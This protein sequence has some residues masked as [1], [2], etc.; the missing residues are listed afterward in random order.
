MA[1]QLIL[2]TL[3]A[4]CIAFS[5]TA[6]APP[7]ATDVARYQLDNL[8]G[9]ITRSGVAIDAATSSDGHG[10]LKVTATGPTTVRLFETGDLDI[11]NARLTY[12]ARLR[13]QDLRGSAYL[14]MWCRFPGQG[15]FFSRGLDS[16]LSGTNDWTSQQTPFFLQPG[17]NPDLVKLNLV[18]NGTGT[19]WID[20]IRL[21]K[22][23]L[24]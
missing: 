6:P 18:V 15:E 11:E 9:V 21:I 8:N 2:I 1:R 20:D 22:G 19:V 12:Q 16:A 17:Q 14:E 13:S 5:C 23:P 10:S 24:Q 4:V 7:P 3:A